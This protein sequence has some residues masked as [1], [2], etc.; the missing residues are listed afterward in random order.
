MM[1][2]ALYMRPGYCSRVTE[3]ICYIFTKLDPDAPPPEYPGECQYA[4][5]SAQRRGNAGPTSQTLDQ[6][7]TGVG[8]RNTHQTTQKTSFHY[9]N[10]HMYALIAQQ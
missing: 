8:L 6:Y 1:D 2:G 9:K 7:C 4:N 5:K 10:I 3:F